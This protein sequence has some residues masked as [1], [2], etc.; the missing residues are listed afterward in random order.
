MRSYNVAQ[1]I[2]VQKS[3]SDIWTKLTAYPT[4]TWRPA[5]GKY[6]NIR[7]VEKQEHW[8]IKKS[9]ENHMLTAPQTF[10]PFCAKHSFLANCK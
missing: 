8:R 10:R 2:R 1:L 3:S 4:L 7:H 6:H 9:I 5:K